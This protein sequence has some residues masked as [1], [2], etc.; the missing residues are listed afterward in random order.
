MLA[1]SFLL[2]QFAAMYELELTRKAQKFYENADASLVRRL[3]QCFDQLRQDPYSLSNVKAM[4]GNYEGCF[5]YRVGDYRVIYRIDEISSDGH[6]DEM[7]EV[8]IVLLIAHRR[9]VYHDR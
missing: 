3:N 9:E 5:R 4:K 7:R 6:S 8:V 2:M 1:K